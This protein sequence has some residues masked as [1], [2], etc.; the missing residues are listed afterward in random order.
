MQDPVN[1]VTGGAATEE[2]RTAGRAAAHAYVQAIYVH[3][4]MCIFVCCGYN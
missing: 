2:R 1:I 3:A 4:M